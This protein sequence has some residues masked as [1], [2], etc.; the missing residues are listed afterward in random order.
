M[1]Y[2]VYRIT[3][4]V[5]GK[6]YVGQ[7]QEFKSRNGVPY[8]YGLT[9]RWCDH[10]STSKHSDT[11]LHT[12]IREHGPNAFT[13]TCLE[14]TT[15]DKID[16]REAY[17]I[18][19]LQTLVPNGYNV[20]SHSRCKHRSGTNVAD[21]YP[22]ATAV[23]LRIIQR[24]GVPH[25]VY[26]YVDTPAGRK[27][28]T[29]GQG[30]HDVFEN[31]LQE[32]QEVV[33]EYRKRGVR[34]LDSDKRTPFLAQQLRRIRIVPYNKTMV[35]VYITDQ[36]GKQSRICFGGKHVSYDDAK[37]Q[38]LQ[39]IEGMTAS[40]VENHTSLQQVAPHSVEANTE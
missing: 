31:V 21:L 37:D 3:C 22:D 17:W 20:A 23:E 38:A 29:F 32:A 13:M 28:L 9:G 18:H 14:T 39:F 25:I 11:P 2:S 6:S 8:N 27:R 5:T 12:A 36:E 1:E 19:Q 7:T 24:N 15:E 40:K 34:V 10:V 30:K 33:E 4:S 26:V 16:S 35:A